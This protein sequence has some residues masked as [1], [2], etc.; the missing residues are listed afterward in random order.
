M[1]DQNAKRDDGKI[2]ITLAPTEILEAVAVTRMYGDMKYG[3]SDNWKTVSVERYRDALCR[4]LIAYLREPYGRDLESNLPHLYHMATNIDFLLSLEIKAGVIP[5]AQTALAQMKRPEAPRTDG[6][7][8]PEGMQV[9]KCWDC[10]YNGR[11]SYEYPCNTCIGGNHWE[12]KCN[13]D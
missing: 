11:P 3:N 13:G 4:H 5:D 2:R 9:I 10:K 12:A 1:D 8:L 6:T 7:A